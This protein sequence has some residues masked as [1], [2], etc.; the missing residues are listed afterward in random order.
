MSCHFIFAVLT[1]ARFTDPARTNT[2]LLSNRGQTPA[3]AELNFLEHAKR[4]DMYGLDLTAAM[5]CDDSTQFSSLCTMQRGVSRAT[6]Q[7]FHP[8]QSCAFHS[9]LIDLCRLCYLREV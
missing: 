3:D 4:I 6:L 8:V 2:L 5:V 9:A 7:S 1:G